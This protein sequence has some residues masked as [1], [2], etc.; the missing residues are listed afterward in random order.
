LRSQP[1]HESRVLVVGS[2]AQSTLN[3]STFAIQSTSD[4]DAVYN[5]LEAKIASWTS[6]RDGWAS[7][8][9]SI[10]E[11]A[12][13]GGLSINEQQVKQ[14]ISASQTLLDQVSVCAAN[15]ASCGS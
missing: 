14:L 1:R 7:Q 3:V 15:P 12:E 9:K 13:F 2:L 4:G 11:G 10:L 5:A 8:M 6:Q